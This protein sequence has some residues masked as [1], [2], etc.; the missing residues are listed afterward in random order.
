MAHVDLAA[1]L[2]DIRRA[3]DRLGD[4]CDGSGVGGDV[5]ACLAVPAGRGVDQRA[6]LVADRKRQAI[7][8]RL[9]RV[10]QPVG[11]SQTK[12]LA[13]GA[14]EFGHI[15]GI[16]RVAERQHRHRVSDLSEAL[17]HGSAH[18]LR[19][20]VGPLEVRKPRLDFGIATLEGIVVCIGYL[21]R[22]LGVVRP[23]GRC[24]ETGEAGE[25]GPC[26]G[27]RQR[28]GIEHFSGGHLATPRVPWPA[29]A[30]LGMR[31][32]RVQSAAIP[33]PWRQ[34]QIAR[35]ETGQFPN[36]SGGRTA[37]RKVAWVRPRSRYVPGPPAPARGPAER[38]RGPRRFRC[39]CRRPWPRQASCATCR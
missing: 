17:R 5:L 8:F 1:H 4:V 13:D 24:E 31:G 26:L 2:Q 10:G 27:F 14:V 22:I 9:G 28:I 21:R 12:V 15:L 32:A 33:A 30:L 39:S 37:V 20:T 7:D 16:K 23:V 11:L 18:L 29:G 19:R 36:G 34:M 3:A 25:L 6:T 38:S 35:R